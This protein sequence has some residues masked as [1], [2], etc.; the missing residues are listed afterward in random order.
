MNTHAFICTADAVIVGGSLGAV[1]A[2]RSLLDMGYSVVMTEECGWIGGQLSAQAVPPDEHEWIEEFGCTRR[3]KEYREAVRGYFCGSAGFSAGLC[4]RGGFD[5]GNS[6][7]SRLAHPPELAHELLLGSL[8]PDIESGRLVLLTGA[9][10]VGAEVDVSRRGG[11]AS[12]EISGKKTVRSIRIRFLADNSERELRAE[13]FVDGTDQGDVLPIVGADYVTGAESRL[14]TR[15]PGAPLRERPA[16]MQPVTWVLSLGL[17][18][19]ES[20]IEKPARYEYFREMRQPFGTG[21]HSVLSCYGPDGASGGARRFPILEDEG[22]LPL[23]TY[24][25]IQFPGYFS[26]PRREI[27]LLNWPQ[28]DYFMANIIETGARGAGGGE[29]GGQS[30]G[31]WSGGRT[32]AKE[33]SY[34]FLYWLQTEAPRR[35]GGRGYPEIGLLRD[36]L[37]TPDGA[38]QFPYIR[39]GRRIRALRTVTA[40]DLLERFHAGL[41]RQKDSVGV[42]SYAI[43]LHITTETHSF[44]YAKRALPFEIPL[45]ALIPRDMTNLIPASKNVGSSH[46]SNGCFRVHPVEWNIGEVAGYLAG[47]CLRRGVRPADMYRE[48]LE[49]FQDFIQDRGVEISWPADM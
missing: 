38:A 40:R 28:N 39:E 2:A 8:R 12:G 43:D 27:S 14:M 34:A 4:A 20:P 16:D 17:N 49:D 37:G 46:L 23:W 11:K 10:P 36:V 31:E 47:C 42:G 25:R 15:E 7:V 5:P 41:P 9:V 24:R 22:D 1:Q 13:V 35:S 33:L 32:G 30:A 6:W 44:L 48:H 45:S 21:G 26:A 3:Y 29:R 19:G 18:C